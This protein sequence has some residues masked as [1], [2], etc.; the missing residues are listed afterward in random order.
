MTPQEAANEI[1]AFAGHLA[2]HKL[3][4]EYNKTVVRRDGSDTMVTWSTA[5]SGQ[6]ALFV[7]PTL[8][9]YV[10][11]VSERQFSV[12]LSD[13]SFLQISL[14]F[15]RGNKLA[16]HRYLLFPSPLTISA[17]D[18]AQ[19]SV[20]DIVQCVP[21]AELRETLLLE[22]PVRFDYD[23]RAAK[24][25]HP[26]SH[27]TTARTDVRIPVF[28]PL[29]LGHLVRFLACQ[30]FASWREHAI[31]REWPLRYFD[32]TLTADEQTQLHLEHRRE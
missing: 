14:T 4:L 6:D 17:E 28:A 13:G 21:D 31:F 32:R 30:V 7:A 15:G 16:K 5:S 1:N 22:G 12:L 9:E 26:V 2:E 27:F 10:R 20:V 19:M 25:G 11:L 18:V 3:A 24:P 8:A 29:C 23:E